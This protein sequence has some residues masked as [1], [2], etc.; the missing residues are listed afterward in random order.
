MAAMADDMGR[1]QRDQQVLADG[2]ANTTKA[3]STNASRHL[4]N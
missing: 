1:C 4:Q 2:F 3:H